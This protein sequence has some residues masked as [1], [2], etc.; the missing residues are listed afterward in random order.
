MTG[1]R[2]RVDF[3]ALFDHPAGADAF[4]CQ[5]YFRIRHGGLHDLVCIIQRQQ[6]HAVG[7]FAEARGVDLEIAAVQ[8]HRICKNRLIVAAI[9]AVHEDQQDQAQ[10]NRDQWQ[11]RYGASCA[12]YCARPF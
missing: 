8:A 3:T 9:Q 6:R 10:H 2:H 5:Q 4:G 7:S 1:D 12:T 11:Y